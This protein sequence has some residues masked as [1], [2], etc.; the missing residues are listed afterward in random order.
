MALPLKAV[1]WWALALALWSSISSFIKWTLVVVKI[2]WANEREKVLH[3]I[4]GLMGPKLVD[5]RLAGFG[6]VLGIRN[7]CSHSRNTAS[8]TFFP[9]LL[10]PH[11]LPSLPQFSFNPCGSMVHK[12]GCIW[13]TFLNKH[14]LGL[15]SRPGESESPGISF[16]NILFFTKFLMW[17]WVSR[18]VRVWKP[19]PYF[20]PFYKGGYG[21]P[22]RILS[23]IWFIC[24][25]N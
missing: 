4:D 20:V 9:F 23:L 18:S 6:T 11:H 16:K 25:E 14:I 22:E 2:L 8:P 7:G 3:F 13:E 19:L 21:Y 5:T 15:H 10:S 17:F 24:C 1:Q 12:T